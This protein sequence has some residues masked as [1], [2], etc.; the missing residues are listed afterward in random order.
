MKTRETCSLKSRS[1][2]KGKPSIPGV[3]EE[4]VL[5]FLAETP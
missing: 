3:D 5:G 2:T 4:K 1:F